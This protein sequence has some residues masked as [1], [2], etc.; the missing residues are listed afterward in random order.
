MPFMYTHVLAHRRA[1]L[2][3]A[4]GYAAGAGDLFRPHSHRHRRA[5]GDEREERS[6]SEA[7]RPIFI[8]SCPMRFPPVSS[9]WPSAICASRKPA[10]APGCMPKS[11]CWPTPRKSSP[12]P[13]RCCAPAE[14]LFGPYRWDRYDIV[15]LPASFPGRRGGISRMR[16][17]SRRARSTGDRSLESV[18][19][20][21]LVASVGRRT[22]ERRDLARCVDQRGA[23]AVYAGPPG[24][25]DV[26][27]AARALRSAQWRGALR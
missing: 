1:Q 24:A 21:A 6:Q 25:G 22:R 9:R 27:R 20:H 11:R 5:R 19:A 14:K 18:V 7:Q 23:R 12:I 16:R 4:A 13:K 17:S 15:V 10:H 2:D 8:R 26:R 3:P